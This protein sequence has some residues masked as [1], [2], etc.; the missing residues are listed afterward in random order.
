MTILNPRWQWLGLICCLAQTL[1]MSLNSGLYATELRRTA[2]VKAVEQA[3]ESVVN[4]HGQKTITAADD[5]AL[6]G[7][8]SKRVNGMGTGIIID[9][10]G[11]ILT[12]HH[13]IDGVKRIEVTLADRSTHI[14]KFIASN[15]AEDLAVI[16]LDLSRKFPVMPIGVSYDL[17]LGEQVIA[18]GNSYGYDHTVSEGIV[19]AIHR[20]VQIN[21]VQSYDDLIQTT[22]DINPGNSGG[23]LMNIDGE[24]VGVNVAVR[25]GAN[26][27][28]FAIPVD[29]A[30]GIA[31]DLMSVQRLENR[32]HGLT[33]KPLSK[34]NT[35]PLVVQT[36][37]KGSPA[38]TAG[39]KSGDVVQVVDGQKLTRPLDVERALL[40]RR[41][42]DPIEFK[43]SRSGEEQSFKVALTEVPHD[44]Y[45]TALGVKLAQV[46]ASQF[47]QSKSR[48]R[49]GL[50]VVAVRADG[51]AAKQGI[52]KGDVLVGMHVWETISL[53]NVDYV[54]SRNDLA[55]ITPIKFLVL[56]NGEALYGHLPLTVKR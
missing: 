41:S 24:L 9:E 38:E 22:A 45:W 6:R 35:N 28:A 39:I 34:T 5:P 29:K 51:P 15:P 16:K 55:E 18:I 23:P 11:Y 44:Q 14:A 13:V 30:M 36:V 53:E 21:E 43:V 50:Q 10:R 26:G 8:Q 32:F 27:I 31:A 47:Q 40:G 42:T 46:P 17:L 54:L 25:A 49:G 4:I 3:R 12:N 52:K 37:E 56:R 7:E 20:S 1:V 19:S 2:L 33:F 48:Y